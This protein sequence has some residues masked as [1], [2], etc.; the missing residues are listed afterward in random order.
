MT[1]EADWA[2]YCRD[3]EHVTPGNQAVLLNDGVEAYPAMLE[4]VR[5]ARSR[6]LVEM[7]DFAEDR[8]GR[9]FR[10]ALSE[11]ARAGVVVYVVYD[12]VGSNASSYAFFRELEAAGVRVRE[13][14]PLEPWRPYW[15]WFRRDHRKMI[16][17]DGKAVVAGMNLSDETAAREQGGKGWRDHAVLVEGPCVTELENLFWGT[18]SGTR[19]VPPASL[20]FIER[21]RRG[22]T[23]VRVLSSLGLFALH[24]IRRSYLT[25]ID[26]ASRSICITN[27][28]FL[29][30]RSIYRRLIAAARRGVRVRVVM[31]YETDHPYVRWAS[32]SLHGRLMEGG[33]E[34]YEY[35][36]TVL[37]AKTAV[38]DGLWSTVGS[39][40]LDHWSLRYN[41]EV[42]LTVFGREF[43]AQMERAFE[44]DLEHCKRLDLKTWRD[45]PL[46]RRLAEE[47]LYLFR[48]AL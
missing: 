31:P 37:H 23:P 29:P 36:R 15:T 21:P 45:R 27:A 48:Y 1:A 30:G 22:N 39:H 26:R 35:Q 38:I 40:N 16:V 19:A 20:P 42:N 28:Y 32:R 9:A 2:G 5:S 6:V 34:L 25:A 8:T 12:A 18:W 7:Y 17:A 13:Y 41:L 3:L 33:V 4:A 24:S 11:R 14:H 10:E 47:A 46:A 43:G 44:R